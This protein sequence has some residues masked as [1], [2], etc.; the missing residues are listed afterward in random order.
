MAR[1]PKQSES[2][3]EE[4]TLRHPDHEH[5]I[6]TS[7]PVEIVRLESQGWRREE[8]PTGEPD[9]TPDS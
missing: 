3:S 2:E 4:V 1:K 8:S 6:T 7:V 9:Q 5:P